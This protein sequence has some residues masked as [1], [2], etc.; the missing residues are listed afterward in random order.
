LEFAALK[1]CLDKFADILWGFPIKI[2]TDCQALHDLL[3]ND[4]LP[5]AHARWRDGILA[6]QIINVR[7]I[8]GRNNP[9]SDGMSRKWAPGSERTTTD[10]STWSINPDWEE[11]TGLVHNI[12]KLTTTTDNTDVTDSLDTRFTNEP[13]F[14]QVVLALCD[15]DHALA[16]QDHKQARHRASKYQI[17]EGKLWHVRGKHSVWARAQ[18]ECVS[19]GEALAMAREIHGREGHFGRNAIK[20]K[21]LDKIKSPYLDQTILAAICECGQCKGFSSTHLHSLSEPITHRHPGELLVGDYCTISKGKGGYNNLGVYL[22]VF[23]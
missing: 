14:Q 23:T 12:F 2:K 21:L 4:K 17:D 5:A 8:K 15:K 22:D 11:R 7:H 18:K 16:L 13:L 10:G 6:H 19:Q 3:L 9:V 20:E 1:F